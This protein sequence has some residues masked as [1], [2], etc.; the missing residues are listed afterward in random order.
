MEPSILFGQLC[1][2]KKLES[3]LE[4]CF[5][6]LWQGQRVNILRFASHAIYHNNLTLLLL[7]YSQKQVVAISGSQIC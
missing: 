3:H 1:F 7:L 5:D 2:T 4:V 6:N